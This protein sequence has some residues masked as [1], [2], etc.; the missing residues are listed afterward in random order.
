MTQ[1]LLSSFGAEK[2]ILNKLGQNAMHTAILAGRKEIARLLLKQ[3]VNIIK[4][5]RGLSPVHMVVL[6][7]NMEMLKFFFEELILN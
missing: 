7:E 1:T 2:N 5:N 6:T 4:D 3:N